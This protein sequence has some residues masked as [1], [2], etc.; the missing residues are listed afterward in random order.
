MGTTI[1]RRRL[2]RALGLA[3]G[4]VI[5]LGI[6]AELAIHL[7]PKGAIRPDLLT[8]LSLSYE[9]NLPTW[10][11]STLLALCGALLTLCA[12]SSQNDRWRWSLLSAGFFYISFD[13][14]VGIHEAVDALFESSSGVLY[15]GWVIP[16]TA[17]V[18]LLG[19]VY[20]PFLRRLPSTSRRRFVIAG[21]IYLC[22]ALLL[23]LP[24]G[25]WT[26]SAGPE[27]LVYAL[28]DLLEESLEIIGLS[29][30][31][32]SL[33]DHLGGKERVYKLRLVD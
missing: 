9:G 18:A 11:S 28:I 24:L 21:A 29:L 26:E 19:L 27:N 8:L 3:S 13:E 25:L 14:S 23:E 20:W 15:F 2:H 6:A 33:I 10:Y 31:I 12:V 5:V 16:A 22:G 30:F 32:A 4:L 17:L 7:L 1:S